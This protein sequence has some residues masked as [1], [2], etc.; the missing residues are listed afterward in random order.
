MKKKMNNKQRDSIR[1][2][3]F[4][5]FSYGSIFGVLVSFIAFKSVLLAILVLFSGILWISALE[6]FSFKLNERG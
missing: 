3:F 1:D 6:R 5:S 2:T 4:S